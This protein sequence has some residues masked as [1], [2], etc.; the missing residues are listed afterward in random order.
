MGPLIGFSSIVFFFFFKQNLAFL[1]LLLA[2]AE[3]CQGFQNLEGQ[4]S[5]RLM[6]TEHM[7]IR[8]SFSYE[9]RLKRAIFL[10]VVRMCHFEEDIHN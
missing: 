4:L 6:C 7:I 10:A 5:E 8:G 2:L 1:K 9:K 3:I